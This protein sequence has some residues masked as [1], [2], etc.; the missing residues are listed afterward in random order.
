MVQTLVDRTVRNELGKVR[1]GFLLDTPSLAPSSWRLHCEYNP[2]P[3]ARDNFLTKIHLLVIWINQVRKLLVPSF[4]R[5]LQNGAIIDSI[6][7]NS[8]LVDS[9]GPSELRIFSDS[10]FSVRATNATFTLSASFSPN[11][12]F[13]FFLFFAS[14]LSLKPPRERAKFEFFPV[15]RRVK[16]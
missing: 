12:F 15:H 11:P 6:R 3:M 8:P 4:A 10:P 14:F 13:S 9:S 16:G 1:N 2:Q 7:V 5:S